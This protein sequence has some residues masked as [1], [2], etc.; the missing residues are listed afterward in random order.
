MHM[1]AYVPCPSYIIYEVR[2]V[3]EIGNVFARR[4]DVAHRLICIDIFTKINRP[5]YTIVGYKS[6]PYSYL[7]FVT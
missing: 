1:Y 6:K 5:I 7:S 4:D 2:N 3:H